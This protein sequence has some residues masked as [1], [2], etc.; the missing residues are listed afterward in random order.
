MLAFPGWRYCPVAVDEREDSETVEDDE[1]APSDR[2]L[3]EAL[4]DEHADS[5]RR[6]VALGDMAARTASGAPLQALL[7]DVANLTAVA[8]EADYAVLLE[9]NHEH[10]RLVVRSGWGMPPAFI[11]KDVS[12]TAK[13]QAGYTI[14]TGTPVLSVD[15]ANDPR[16]GFPT[17]T[18]PFRPRGALSVP[19]VIR[20][21]TWGVLVAASLTD[22]R[23]GSADLRFIQAAA[24]IMGLSIDRAAADTARVESETRL[25]LALDSVRMGIWDYRVSDE[26]LWMSPTAEK[27][28]GI[29]PGTFDGSPLSIVAR[30]PSADLD[31]FL[32]AARE[33]IG[34]VEGWH[35]EFSLRSA[36]DELR[37]FEVS[38]RAVV[39][40]DGAV[41]RIVGV[42]A[43]VTDRREA[44]SIR[45]S[46]VQRAD[47][48]RSAAVA[49]RERL[50]YLASAG[51]RF[52]ELLDAPTLA[53]AIVAETVGRISDT[54]VVDL[55]AGDGTTQSVALGHRDPLR[56]EVLRDSH[57]YQAHGKSSR[58]TLRRMFERGE[59]LFLPEISAELLVRD[60]VDDEHSRLLLA[61]GT[62]SVILVPLVAR[63]QLVGGI[64]LTRV[65]DSPPFDEDDLALAVGLASRAAVALDNARLFAARAEVVRALQETLIPPALPD[66]EGVG[67]AACYRVAEGGVDIGGDFYDAFPVNDSVVA[68]TIGDVSGKGPSA[69]AITGIVRQSLRA[70]A[71]QGLGPAETLRSVNAVLVDQI[72]DTRFCTALMMEIEP[73]GSGATVRIANAGHL[74]PYLVTASGQA[75]VIE[76]QG[77]LL[78]VLPEISLSEHVVELAV[79]DSIV[80]VTDGVTEARAGMAELGEE[81]VL[82]G[83]GAVK[84]RASAA[85]IA[86]VVVA[87]TAAFSQG[88]A[89][90]DLAVM[91]IRARDE[92]LQES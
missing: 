25:D 8:L 67:L 22:R 92:P 2:D 53:N 46:L 23:F 13:N 57:L 26:R 80:M 86:N 29:S 90:D 65:E 75:N 59:Q 60:A 5:E 66:V 42:A 89:R 47:D 27:M 38:A 14:V 63:G 43:D 62:H 37:W 87:H 49:A 24:H 61:V 48:A 11:G 32:A 3:A 84:P 82:E 7:E 39:S 35:H 36:D 30:V 83:L 56:E 45:A 88:I 85:E 78:G 51:A 54:C 10:G 55:Y 1:E 15:T 6:S 33:G 58:D 70:L 4:R 17:A 74:R 18:G 81:G 16:F 73:H 31:A 41:D 64:A 44:E 52:A 77:T 69:A 40:D 34:S 76:C 72:D 50:A 19:V 20:G 68:V 28:L 79:G 71:P 9:Q 12:A 21:R 91:V